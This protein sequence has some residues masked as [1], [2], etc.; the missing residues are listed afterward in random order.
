MTHTF[1]FL[2]L[3]I[4]CFNLDPNRVLDVVLECFECRPHLHSS[5]IPL[6]SNFLNNRS[7]LAQILAFKFSFYHE[8]SLITPESLYEVTAHLLNAKL[9]TLDDIYPYLNPGDATIFEYCK[10]ELNDAKTYA[11]KAFISAA[12]EKEENKLNEADRLILF[13]NNQKLGLCLALLKAGDWKNAKDLISRLPECYVVSHPNITKQ[14]C[15][16]IHYVI[17]DFYR[18]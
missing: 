16:L 11:K 14:L 8:P 5:F 17:D 3:F 4:G 1:L 7:T 13:D 10:N 2:L 6:L 15:S 12:P 18:S 9:F